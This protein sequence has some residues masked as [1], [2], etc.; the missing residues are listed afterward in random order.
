MNLQGSYEVAAPRQ[1]VWEA[2]NHPDVLRRCTPGCQRLVVN[3]NGGYDTDL[4]VSVG[5]IKGRFAGKIEVKDRL[6]GAR[7]Q[8]AVS[9]SGS[10][11][12]LNASG[13][14]DLVEASGKTLV[15]YSGDAQVGGPI[16]SVGQRMVD[17][18]ARRLVAQFFN[19]FAKAMLEGAPTDHSAVKSS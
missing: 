14:I 2:L 10:A 3:A 12:F 1:R 6:P 16:A 8:L 7:Y 19:C 18:V 5:A 9:A 4:E 15:H 11:G 13:I 17:G